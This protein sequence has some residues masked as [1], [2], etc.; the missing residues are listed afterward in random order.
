M[1]MK[2]F[3][4]DAGGSLIK[5]AY[6]ENE[7]LHVKKYPYDELESL[8]GWLS[9]VSRSSM[10]RIT[11]GKSGKLEQFLGDNQE[12]VDEFE[13]VITGVGY[14]LAEAHHP[15]K[16][17]S[18][19]VNIGTGTSY[20]HFSEENSKRIIGSGIGGGTLVGLGGHLSDL[21]NFNEIVLTAKEGD[22]SKVDLQV[23]DIYDPLE[24]PIPG[25]FTASNFGKQVNDKAEAKDLLASL[26]GMIAESCMLMAV[27]AA[28]MYNVQDIIYIGGAL[29]G[30]RLLLQNLEE[31]TK[32]FNYTPHFL[33]MGEFCGAIGALIYK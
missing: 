33:D 31:A 4:V 28:A 24:P 15:A 25:N 32:A 21:E 3:G 11:G 27:Q 16:K 12:M 23:K 6:F 17:G 30:N 8:I 1:G 18:I 2:C 29:A 20:Y 26:T 9:I 14:L 5:I 10:Y 22:R 13:A 19:I 7:R